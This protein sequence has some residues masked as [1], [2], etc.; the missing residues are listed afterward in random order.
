MEFKTFLKTWKGAV[1]E[2]NFNRYLI[3]GQTIALIICAFG[4]INEDRVT[5]V[6]PP[7]LSEKAE[8]ARKTASTGYKQAWGLYI[9]ELLG[10]ITPNNVDFIIDS[11]TSMMAPDLVSKF[12]VFA[13]TEA[14][15][16][17]KN[18]ITGQYEPRDVRFEKA[19][20]KIFITGQQ[21]LDTPGTS[22]AAPFTRVFEVKISIKQ[23]MPVVTHFDTYAGMPR[24]QDAVE[25][26]TRDQEHKDQ[27]D[28]QKEQ[29]ALQARRRELREQPGDQ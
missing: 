6:T 21:R 3:A 17:K 18:G 7:T 12:R 14:D 4:L 13:A 16:I 26:L 11:L 9:A 2:N 20:D 19:T 15:K 10:N 22:A 5:V 1:S 27:L 29:E 25:K 23:G 24:T 8:I 28:Q